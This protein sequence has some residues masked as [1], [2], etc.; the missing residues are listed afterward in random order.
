MINCKDKVNKL[1]VL[2]VY[3]PQEG[4]FVKDKARFENDLKKHLEKSNGVMADFNTH[5]GS[6]R[7]GTKR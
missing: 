6:S 3:A 2:Q 1:S 5:V 7:G 4:C